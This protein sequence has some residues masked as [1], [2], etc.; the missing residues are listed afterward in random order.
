MSRYNRKSIP[1]RGTKLRRLLCLMLRP[2]G[3]VAQDVEDWIGHGCFGPMINRLT[4]DYGYDVRTFP[5]GREPRST[6]NNAGPK[7][8]AYRIVGQDRKFRYRSFLGDMDKE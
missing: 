1:G 2:E 4:D 8:R 6:Y 5:T 3:V 7:L